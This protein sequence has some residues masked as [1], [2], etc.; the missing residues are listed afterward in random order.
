MPFISSMN[1]VPS[2]RRRFLADS[3]RLG[4]AGWLALQLPLL[5]TFAACA[6]DTA[7]FVTLTPSEARTMRAFA[8]QI[9]PSSDGNPGAEEAGAVYFADR[10][11]GTPYFA[12]DAKTVRTGL[13]DLDARARA[14]GERD[15]FASLS[16]AKQIAIMRAI[17]HGEFFATA[18]KL[19]ITGTF[20]DASYGGNRGG[21][22]WSI[23]G[24]DHQGSYAAPFGWYDAQHAAPAATTERRAG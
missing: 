16:P 10:A 19:V 9:I 8:A 4:T 6:R 20:A 13:A 22:G 12:A 2:T 21:I 17:E 5:E 11:L 18:R 15:G 23:I 7:P 1:A 14:M 3:T 24:I